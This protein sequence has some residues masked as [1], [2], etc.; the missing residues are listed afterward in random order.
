M[1]KHKLKS[2]IAD[3]TQFLIAMLY[4]L[5][6]CLSTLLVAF[7]SSIT[8]PFGE[9]GDIDKILPDYFEEDRKPPPKAYHHSKPD[10]LENVKT[11]QEDAM[12]EIGF[13]FRWSASL[14]SSAYSSP[15]IFPS[16]PQGKKQIFQNTFYQ[17]IEIV[18]YD[19]YKPWLVHSIS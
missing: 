9:N 5:C 6:L 18:G 16:G 8:N 4:S 19:G 15:V 14:G 3:I 12:C 1:T 11:I 17:Y 7:S 2:R 13:R 10:K